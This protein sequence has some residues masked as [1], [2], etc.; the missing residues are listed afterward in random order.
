MS[1]VG[2]LVSHRLLRRGLQ[3]SRCLRFLAHELDGPHNIRFL[4]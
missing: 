1:T 4:V 2:T 3:M